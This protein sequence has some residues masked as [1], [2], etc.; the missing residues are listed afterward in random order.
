MEGFIRVDISPSGKALNRVRIDRV[1]RELN[2][3]GTYKPGTIFSDR[4]YFCEASKDYWQTCSYSSIDE[5]PGSLDF[6][7]RW[8][9]SVASGATRWFEVKLD[10]YMDPQVLASTST[11]KLDMSSVYTNVQIDPFVYIDHEWEYANEYTLKLSPGMYVGPKFD[12]AEIITALQ[13]LA[14]REISLGDLWLND[15]NGDGRIG[16]AEIINMLQIVSR[17]R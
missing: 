6:Y 13:L 8:Y 12:L 11:G 17:I 1:V 2:W 14:G 9:M 3:D 15:T 10:A 5:V 4:I 7:H 16:Q